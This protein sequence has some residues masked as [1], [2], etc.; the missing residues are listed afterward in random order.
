MSRA[1]AVQSAAASVV[2]E[3]RVM[4]L[5]G[6]HTSLPQVPLSSSQRVHYVKRINLVGVP[7]SPPP[8]HCCIMIII[9]LGRR[10]MKM[11]S[12]GGGITSALR[13]LTVLLRSSRPPDVLWGQLG[14]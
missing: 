1:T 6:S 8:K 4:K 13:R 11:A 12:N 9:T 14:T 3:S 10:R 2:T 7:S 5:L